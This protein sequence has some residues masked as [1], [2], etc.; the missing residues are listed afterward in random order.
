MDPRDAAVLAGS[1]STV[2]FVTSYLPMLIKAYRTRDLTSY[3]R[4][5]LV[6]ANVGNGVY[7]VYV[8]TLPVG[9]VWFLHGFYLFSTALMLLWH[10]VHADRDAGAAG[11][12]CP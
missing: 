2:I 7:S 1:V 8:V 9:P 10:W 3:S 12:P 11:D 5:S 6:L 4:G